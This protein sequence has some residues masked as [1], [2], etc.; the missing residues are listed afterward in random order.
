MLHIFVN[1]P[2]FSGNECGYLLA[3]VTSHVSKRQVAIR[4]RTRTKEKGFFYADDKRE[5]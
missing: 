5:K 3:G 1:V 2:V 4:K